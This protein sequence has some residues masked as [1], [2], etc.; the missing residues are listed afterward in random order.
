MD[1]LLTPLARVLPILLLGRIYLVALV[2][3]LVGAVVV[4]CGECSPGASAW[5][6]RPPG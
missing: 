3:G 5:N 1:L 4:C 6:P 2:W